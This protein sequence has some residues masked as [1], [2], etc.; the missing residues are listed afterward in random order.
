MAE[1]SERCRDRVDA[2]LVRRRPDEPRDRTVA[3]IVT[4]IV[5]VIVLTTLVVMLAVLG[6]GSEA[7]A[8]DSPG[9][10]RRSRQV[11]A[12]GPCRRERLIRHPKEAMP[13]KV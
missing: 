12:D 6:F 13:L 4:V 10:R 11:G 3:L 2:G 8:C 9:D 5:I 1:Q 7:M